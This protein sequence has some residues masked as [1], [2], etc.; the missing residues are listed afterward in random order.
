[1]TWLRFSFFCED[2]FLEHLHKLGCDAHSRDCVETVSF[3]ILPVH[4]SPRRLFALKCFLF[5]TFRLH[6]ERKA[7]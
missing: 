1:M 3:D 2:A 7:W 4:H 5:S 6:Q